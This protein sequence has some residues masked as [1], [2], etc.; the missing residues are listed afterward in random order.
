MQRSWNKNAFSDVNNEKR[1]KWCKFVSPFL[2]NNI[3]G[4]PV[5][6]MAPNVQIKYSTY[7]WSIYR[8]FVL[9]RGRKRDSL[10]MMIFVVVCSKCSVVELK[11]RFETWIARNE[12][13]VVYWFHFYYLITV[14]ALVIK[15]TCVQNGQ[16][17]SKSSILCLIGRSMD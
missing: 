8:L 13:N 3:Y 14:L 5:L 16:K 1:R 10:Q 9:N 12:I 15:L 2:F 4:L 11:T 6:T 17:L 7:D